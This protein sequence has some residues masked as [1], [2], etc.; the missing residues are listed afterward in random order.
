[1]NASVPNARNVDEKLQ[2]RSGGFVGRGR[3]LEEQM[4]GEK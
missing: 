1:M 4:G 2:R 3:I